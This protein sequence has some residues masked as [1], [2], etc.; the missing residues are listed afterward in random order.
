GATKI[1]KRNSIIPYPGTAEATETIIQII[2]NS[3][4]ENVVTT[5][6]FWINGLITKTSKVRKKSPP[7]GKWLAIN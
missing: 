4:S 3:A 7:R 2:T 5:W 6:V 1:G